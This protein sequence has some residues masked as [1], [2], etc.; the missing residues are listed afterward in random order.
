[1][2]VVAP[3]C[4]EELQLID[5]CEVEVATEARQFTLLDVLSCFGVLPAGSQTEVCQNQFCF[6]EAVLVVIS[7]LVG[8]ALHTTEKDVFELEVVVN[9]ATFVDELEHVE[10]V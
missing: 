6:H 3:T 10:D 5:A 8:D 4:S 2:Q 1:M 9:V 7:L